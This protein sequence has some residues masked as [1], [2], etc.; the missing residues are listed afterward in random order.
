MKQIVN[1][2][3]SMK[4]TGVLLFIFA[5]AIGSATFIENDFGTET[6]RAI[7][8]NAVWF[9]LLLFIIGINLSF[10]IYKYRLWKKNK[11]TMLVFHVSFLI[12]FIGAAI[13]RHLGYEGTMHIRE[14]DT[15]SSILTAQP[16]IEIK[17]DTNSV[18]KQLFLSAIT[19]N[20]FRISTDGVTATL[21]EYFPHA[22]ETIVDDPAGKPG[23]MLVV[24]INQSRNDTLLMEG[25]TFDAGE[26][27]FD[28]ASGEKP[29]AHQISVRM[30]NGSMQFRA[31]A[32]V[33]WMRMSDRASGSFRAGVYAPLETGKLHTIGGISF[34]VKAISEKGVRAV[35]RSEQKTSFSGLVVTLSGYGDTTEVSL[36]GGKGIPATPTPI[37]LGGKKVTLSYGSKTIKLPF[38][39]K[40]ND[41]ILE[42]Y[43]GSNS[44]SS[45]E[46][47]VN[48]IDPEMHIDEPRRIYMNHILTHRGFRFYQSSYDMDELGTV[49]SVA[50]DPGMIP[51]YIGYILLVVGM[52]VNLFNRKG[53]LAR[54]ERSFRDASNGAKSAALFVVFVGS[55]FSGSAVRA[56]TP[57]FPPVDT[58][59]AK[60]FERLPVQDVQGRV[61][62]MDSLAIEI[63]NKISRTTNLYGLTPA[64]TILG[65]FSDP[66]RWSKIPVIRISHPEVKRLLGIGKNQDYAAFADFLDNTRKEPYKLGEA[67]NIALRKSESTR[68]KFDKALIKTDEMASICYMIFRGDMFR[69]FP[70][71]S[72]P[73][74]KW[75]SALE[76]NAIDPSV[77]GEVQKLLILYLEAVRNGSSTGDWSQAN[78]A[79][80]EIEAFQ[81]KHSADL[82]P[83]DSA[84]SVEILFNHL[85][86][87]DRISGFYMLAG[88]VLLIF[89]F[90]EIVQRKP[91]NVWV[92]RG[93][94]A[95]FLLLFLLHTFGLGLRWYISGHAPWSNGYESLIY[96]SWGIA[97]SGFVF[98]RHMQLALSAAG[99]LAGLTLFVA[100]LSWMDPQITNLVPVLKSYWL[101]I[102]V[103]VISASYGFLGLGALLGIVVLLLITFRK[104]AKPH[105]DDAIRKIVQIDE[106]ALLLGIVLL[107]IGNLLG[108]VWANESWGRYWSWDPKETWTLVSIL[109]Y[110]T[111]LHFRYIPSLN[112]AFVFASWST[113]SYATI[114]MTYFGVNYFLS[115][116]HSYAAGDPVPVPPFVYYTLGAVIALIILAYSKRDSKIPL[117]KLDSNG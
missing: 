95:V 28:F 63:V 109:V 3:S 91:I 40:L 64:Q 83:S 33:T 72:D 107:S 103:S 84:I 38:Q 86:I 5:I 19:P 102:H 112:T 106:M 54:L 47:H 25:E 9:E 12:I 7:V 76:G 69:I 96:I 82:I 59:H 108:A 35:V 117:Q 32:P 101:T 93:I 36:I 30:V 49:L 62:P 90:V 46:S 66:D 15:S 26:Y 1:L 74:K 39:L 57:T 68:N 70:S 114:L 43:P 22:T 65:M 21:K 50:N 17:T 45:Y 31:P 16:Y 44:P 60:Q 29:T 48:L 104:K 51:T 52:L 41:F 61:K 92:V 98:G 37:M 81:R 97:L 10:S 23:A 8:Y 24:S 100:H 113:L 34:V 99:I 53:R 73:L 75:H 18:D 6:A 80:H 13:T 89:T 4:L 71:P 55:L 110:A 94:D 105:I 85:N 77:R 14:N 42:R 88:F 116:L 58:E 56:E 87:F 67:V 27:R 11:L 2:L 115:G 78:E 20:S 79:L 111:L